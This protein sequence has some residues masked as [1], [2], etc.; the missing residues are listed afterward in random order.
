MSTI[1]VELRGYLN[2]NIGILTPGH[3][4]RNFQWATDVSQLTAPVNL[5]DTSLVYSHLYF[6]IAERKGKGY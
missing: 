2:F 3:Q 1:A 5:E 6:Q 4:K